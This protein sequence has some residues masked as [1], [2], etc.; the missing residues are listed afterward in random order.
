MEAPVLFLRRILR[1][2]YPIITPEGGERDDGGICGQ[3]VCPQC[4]G[5]LSAPSGNGP[6]C[7]DPPAAGTVSDRRAAWRDVCRGLLPPRRRVSCPNTGE[8]GGGDISCPGGLRRRRAAPSPDGAAVRR[9]LRHGRRRAGGGTPLRRGHSGGK[10]YFLHGYRRKS[11]AGNSHGGLSAAVPGVPCGGGPR[12]GGRI[13][14]CALVPWWTERE[15]HRPSR[16]REQPAGSPYRG[17]RSGD[18]SRGGGGTSGQRSGRSS[19]DKG[20][21]PDS[22]F[23]PAPPV[24]GGETPF[25]PLQRRGHTGGADACLPGGLGADRRGI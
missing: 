18:L 3:C 12:R 10:R 6:S 22:A 25:D 21:S 24:A 11:A 1:E 7:R 8:G 17:A 9:F 15:D 4:S 5:G 14:G 2:G 13:A 23:C 20:R 16:H 19:G